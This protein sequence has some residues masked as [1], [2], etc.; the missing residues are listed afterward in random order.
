MDIETPNTHL[1]SISIPLVEGGYV[2]ISQTQTRS[3]AL[4]TVIGADGGQGEAE[5]IPRLLTR[6]DCEEIAAALL[7]TARGEPE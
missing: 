2:F 3:G 5:P 1:D 7:R 4:R 6:T